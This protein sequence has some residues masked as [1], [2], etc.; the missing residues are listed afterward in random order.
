MSKTI[1][2]VET[3]AEVHVAP[4]F[5]T[6]P[7]AIDTDVILPVVPVVRFQSVGIDAAVS[8]FHNNPCAPRRFWWLVNV[9]PFTLRIKTL[10]HGGNVA[11]FDHEDFNL[12]VDEMVGLWCDPESQVYRLMGYRT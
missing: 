11:Y 1:I 6:V 12:A 7:I 2:T 3:E 10:D 8:Q 5:V 4:D 9:G